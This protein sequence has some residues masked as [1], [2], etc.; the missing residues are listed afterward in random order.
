MAFINQHSSFN[1][2]T[3]LDIFALPPTQNSVEF[4]HYTTCRPLAPLSNNSPIEFVI[5]GTSDEYIDLA[6]TM[7]YLQVKITKPENPSPAGGAPA[8]GR[9]IHNIAPINN[10]LHAMF[11]QVD[12]YLNQKCISPPS[13]C[14]NY[15]SYIE[16]LLNYGK[17]AKSSHLQSSFWYKDTASH[18]EVTGNAGHAKRKELTDGDKTIDLFGNIHCD[19]FNQDKYLLNGVELA[20]K[21]IPA[22]TQ[23]HLMSNIAQPN[24][25]FEFITAELYVRKVKVNPTI[26]LGHAEGLLRSSAKYPITR[27]DIKQ[28]TLPAPIQNKTLDN[29]YISTLPKRCIIGMVRNSAFNGNYESN[30]FKFENFDLNY[31][32]VFIDS[33]QIPSKPFTPDF[34]NGNFIRE[35]NSL[36]SGSG[37]HFSDNGNDI[38]KHEYAN[39]FTLFC[40]DTTPDLSSNNTNW[41]VQKNGTLRIELRFANPLT[42]SITI[43]VFSEFDSLIE[44]DRNRQIILDY[45]S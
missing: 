4:G 8:A 31:L 27:V 19:I 12:V 33:V 28:I 21:F 18:M 6:H 40:F 1:L 41:N 10:W 23:F 13:N 24:F 22:N 7:I 34:A 26:L 16:N 32:S 29:I 35:Y 30:P 45:S 5:S 20:I 38:S 3:E 36:F 39:G 2:K 14:Y 43:I 25:S 37:I 11:S 17:D 15:R 44:I 42:E 9:N